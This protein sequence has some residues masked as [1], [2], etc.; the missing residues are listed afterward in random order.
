[1]YSHSYDPRTLNYLL[2]LDAVLEFLHDKKDDPPAG[3]AAGIASSS[4]DRMGEPVM[5]IPY[6]YLACSAI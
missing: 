3:I 1:M 2:T 6:R 5:S 4:G